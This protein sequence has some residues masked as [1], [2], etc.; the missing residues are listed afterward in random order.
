MLNAGTTAAS[1]LNPYTTLG[2]TSANNL[3]AALS[4]GGSLTS[5]FSFNPNTIASN[6]DY[7]FQLSQ[8]IQAVKQAAAATGTLGSSQ[9]LKGI[10]NYAGGLASSEIGQAYNQALGTYQ[11]NYS[12]TLNSLQAGTN[13]GLSAQ[14][15]ANNALIQTNT[16]AGNY[17][18]NNASN[19][20]QL[21]LDQGQ[22]KASGSIAQGNIWGGFANSTAAAAAAAIAGAG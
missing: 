15:S 2:S 22:A 11:T 7:Q 6:P 19:I 9:T 3:T 13:T 16:T 10:A 1:N 18:V 8:G 21:L 20:E 14:N 5:Q 4:P 17:G 12:N